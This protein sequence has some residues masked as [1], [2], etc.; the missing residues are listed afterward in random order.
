M[1]TISYF[2]YFRFG[3][4]GWIWVL[5]ASDP[6]LCIL[7]TY[8]IMLTDLYTMLQFFSAAKI[9]I[10]PLKNLYSFLCFAQNID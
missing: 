4:E 6:D 5:I 7:L 10:F 1:P 3:F 9:T 2:R 8:Y